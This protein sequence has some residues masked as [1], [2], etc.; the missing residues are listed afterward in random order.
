MLNWGLKAAISILIYRKLKQLRGEL[1]GH[2]W[3]VHSSSDSAPRTTE[4]VVGLLGTLPGSCQLVANLQGRSNG[5]VLQVGVPKICSNSSLSGACMV[6]NEGRKK[7]NGGERGMLGSG[8]SRWEGGER[9]KG[10]AKLQK[11]PSSIIFFG[12][13]TDSYLIPLV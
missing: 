11:C 2:T 5:R 13:Q 3:G 7:N 6:D 4:N 9:R 1:H 8:V 10:L 12:S